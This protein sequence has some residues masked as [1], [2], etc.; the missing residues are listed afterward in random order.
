MSVRDSPKLSTVYKMRRCQDEE[1]ICASP[2]RNSVTITGTLMLIVDRS[3]AGTLCETSNVRDLLRSSIRVFG[4]FRPLK[5]QLKCAA[6]ADTTY[7]T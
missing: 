2:A 4:V 1:E 5:K 7:S 6:V 3:S